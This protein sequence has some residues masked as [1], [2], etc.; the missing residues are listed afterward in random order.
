MLINI[1]LQYQTKDIENVI[2]REV[3]F[4]NN[5][6]ILIPLKKEFKTLTYS[7]EDLTFLGK[8]TEV[9]T[10]IQIITIFLFCFRYKTRKQKINLFDSLKICDIDSVRKELFLEIQKVQEEHERIETDIIIENSRTI[11]V[12]E[13]EV[14]FFLK[15]LQK[16]DINDI[17]YRK[18]LINVLIDR[19]YLYDDNLTIIFNTNDINNI[20]EISTQDIEKIESSLMGSAGSPKNLEYFIFQV[21]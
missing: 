11:N 20:K 10:T 18:L 2:V 5:C 17:R 12:T 14:V 9:L 3:V 21:F 1:L 15:G 16:G 19:V 13:D 6:V 7:K 4:N 8:V